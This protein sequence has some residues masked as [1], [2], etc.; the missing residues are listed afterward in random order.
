M[1]K[2]QSDNFA[3]IMKIALPIIVQGLVF[4]L[5]TVV[6]KAF[7]GKLDTNY[8]SAV[9]VAQLPFLTSVDAFTAICTGLT[10]IVATRYV[11]GKFKDI[12]ISVNA[13]ISFNLLFS[14]LLFVVWQAF[15]DT[16]FSWI[17]VSDTLLPYCKEYVH[18]I[19]YFLVLFGI[20]ISLQAALQGMGKTKVIMY[21]GVIKVALNT[22]LAWIL[23]SGRFG[24]PAMH[25]KGAALAGAI[26]NLTGT[27]ILIVYFA[28]SKEL[29]ANMRLYDILRFRWNSYKE[30]IRLGLP[31]GMEYLL[32]NISNLILI[33]LLN[34]QGDQVVA[35]YTLT[36]TLEIFV[37]MIFNG[38]ARAT[39]TLVGNHMGAGNKKAARSIMTSSILSS[40]IFV[41]TFCLLFALIPKPLLSI[42][43]NDMGLIQASAFYLLVRGI[44]MFPKSLNVVVGHGNR[45]NGDVKWMLFT[46]I[47][48]SVFV[49]LSAYSLLYILR[50]GVM[51]IYLTLFSDEL[52]RSILNTIRFYRGNKLKFT[53]S[54]HGKARQKI[55]YADKGTP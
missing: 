44:T 45:A 53:L 50:L 4:Q 17:N 14:L 54:N 52:L 30:V 19:S 31:T 25:V 5:Q 20:D 47:I 11:A 24:F 42:F 1:M 41:L 28:V 3:L 48:G 43:S 33:R 46:Q 51:A 38:I 16:I 27:L 23:I 55:S 32:W 7:L 26:A 8:L 49:V 13:S 22:L 40:V 21:V 37:Y 12:H 36:F 34:K 2:R 10:I 29:S 6:D 9:G 18:T 15:P 39:L 35:V